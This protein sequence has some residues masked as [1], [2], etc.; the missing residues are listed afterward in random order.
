MSKI[1]LNTNYHL[2]LEQMQARWFAAL[3]AK[4][5]QFPSKTEVAAKLKADEEFRASL[6]KTTRH[7]LEANYMPYMDTIAG[8]LDCAPSLTRYAITDPKLFLKLV[9]GVFSTYQFR[10]VGRHSWPEARQTILD[11]DRRVERPF[12]AVEK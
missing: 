7:G 8:Y 1:F 5:I 12:K 10:L 6:Y 3:N 9:F 4:R 11:I 2:V